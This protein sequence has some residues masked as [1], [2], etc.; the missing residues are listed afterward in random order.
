MNLRVCRVGGWPEAWSTFWLKDLNNGLALLI[1]FCPCGL[2]ESQF[3]LLWRRPWRFSGSTPIIP[4]APL[5]MIPC[6]QRGHNIISAHIIHISSKLSNHR[7]T[8]QAFPYTFGSTSSFLKF[9]LHN[10]FL[11]VVA[12]T[13]IDYKSEADPRISSRLSSKT[14]HM[15]ILMY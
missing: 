6:L 2:V 15:N 8:H 4:M 5:C 1:F 14:K 11:K 13:N 12:T 9:S 10:R 3:S 7:S